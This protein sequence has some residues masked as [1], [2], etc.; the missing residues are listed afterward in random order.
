MKTFIVIVICILSAISAFA[1][2]QQR[3]DE[4]LSEIFKQDFSDWQTESADKVFYPMLTGGW[5]F[6]PQIHEADKVSG[7][8]S[9]WTR[10]KTKVHI[11]MNLIKPEKSEFS[12]RM[13]TIRNISPPSY[14]I[15]DL[16][17]QAYLIKFHHRIEIAFLKENV[18]TRINL[19]YPS[20]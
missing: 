9:I 2:T 3:L 16:G 4:K 14:K 13:F 20:K 11:W 5:K 6:N 8:E 7:L 17:A 18:F 15:D 1:Q 12:M 10:E 19:D